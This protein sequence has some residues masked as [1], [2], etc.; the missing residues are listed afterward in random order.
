M[1]TRIEYRSGEGLAAG[2][3]E[4][5]ER[6]GGRTATTKSVIRLAWWPTGIEP[7]AYNIDRVIV[8]L[9]WGRARVYEKI[10]V[11]K[12]Q[13]IELFSPGVSSVRGAYR[14]K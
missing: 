8:E 13:I 5:E 7:N 1:A 6:S 14:R 4:I 12:E 3:F 9:V 10:P 11:T 2:L